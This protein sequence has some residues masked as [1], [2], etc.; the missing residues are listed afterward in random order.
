M[1]IQWP[2]RSEGADSNP[3]EVIATY[4][5]DMEMAD[6]SLRYANEY[7]CRFTVRDGK[8]TRFL[9]YYDTGRLIT[10]FGGTIDASSNHSLRHSC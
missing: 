9:E 5:S 6:K 10:G 2:R 3:G 4:K 7:I 1:P 8:L